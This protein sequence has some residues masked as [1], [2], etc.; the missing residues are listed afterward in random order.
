MAR[1]NW[2]FGKFRSQAPI[3]RCTSDSSGNS[4]QMHRL[5]HAPQ[6]KPTSW[7]SGA[8]PRHVL[9]REQYGSAA[10]LVI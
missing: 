8:R 3:P 1:N 5:P 4:P 2:L 7:R 6:M 9:P 10:E